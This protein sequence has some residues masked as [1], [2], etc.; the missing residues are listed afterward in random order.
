MGI[1]FSVVAPLILPI[2]AVVFGLFWIGYSKRFIYALESPVDT[3]GLLYWRA[4]HQ[5]FVGLYTAELCLFG[6]FMLR[7][8][9]IQAILMAFAFGVTVLIQYVVCKNYAS[10]VM[11][12]SVS[13]A[14]SQEEGDTSVLE[15]PRRGLYDG[16]LPTTGQV[17]F[18]NPVLSMRVPDVW[19]LC[20]DDTRRLLQTNWGISVSRKGLL[21]RKNK[22]MLLSGPPDDLKLL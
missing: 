10:L 13:Q 15:T 20:S 17:P 7:S 1:I 21:P 14:S 5:L 2:G 6:L 12:L 4:L 22:V 9:L 18:V 16:Q 3:G 11:H 8:A 19:A